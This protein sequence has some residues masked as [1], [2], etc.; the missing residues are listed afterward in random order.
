[1]IAEILEDEVV[2][3]ADGSALRAAAAAGLRGSRVIIP[4]VILY[5]ARRRGM[6]D[7]DVLVERIGAT[8]FDGEDDLQEL[9]QIRSL[10]PAS[11][12]EGL[13]LSSITAAARSR[14]DAPVVLL[15]DPAQ[16]KDGRYY[17]SGSK[18]VRVV[19]I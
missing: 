10:K 2:I 11:R 5:E 7:A 14:G 16:I 3:I 13:I 6:V 15:Y 9:L 12:G 19:E 18:S 4:D 8:V 1:M 17:V